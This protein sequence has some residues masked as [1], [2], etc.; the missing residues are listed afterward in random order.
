MHE[1]PESPRALPAELPWL[2]GTAALLGVA[3]TVGMA[4][5][6]TLLTHSPLLLIALAP[7]GRHL[8]LAAPVTAFA[9]LLMV[10][11][12]RR[13]LA[14]VVAYRV[15]R[16]YGERGVLWVQQRYPRAGRIVRTFEAL[17]R[18]AGPLLLLV[19]PGPPSC[20]LAGVTGMRMTW[21]LPIATVGQMAWITVT[22]RVGDALSAWL[23]PLL[24]LLREHMLS[25][26]LACIALVLLARFVRRGRGSAVLAPPQALRAIDASARTDA[27]PNTGEP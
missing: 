25:T 27:R 2:L 21:F 23:L 6:P 10:A 20:A 24:A 3:G 9:P 17:F 22:Y 4:L 16:A 1:P 19:A 5:A 15:G 8:L 13:M 12:V 18:R 7:I 26:T 14:C 11:T